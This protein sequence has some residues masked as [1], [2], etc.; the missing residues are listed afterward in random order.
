MEKKTVGIIG[1]VGGI[2]AL[3]SVALPW[4]SIT[5]FGFSA[6]FSGLDVLTS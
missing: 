3:V 4:M 2:L 5:V 1:L 6:S